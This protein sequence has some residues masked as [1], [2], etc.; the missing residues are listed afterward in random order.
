MLA[1]PILIVNAISP[2]L[3]AM[4]VD[5]W[6]WHASQI[7]LVAMSAASFLAMEWMSRWYEA[8]RKPAAAL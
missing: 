1:A 7:V 3:F 5:R 2:T 8:R 4:I 6:G